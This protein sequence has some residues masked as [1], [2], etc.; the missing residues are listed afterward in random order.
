M[1]DLM[2]E[3]LRWEV[4]GFVVAMLLS[5]RMHTLR[6]KHRLQSRGWVETSEER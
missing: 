3:L 4:E 5:Y 2:S 6:D 1:P